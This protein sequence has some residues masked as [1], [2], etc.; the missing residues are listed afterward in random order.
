[1]N[2]GNPNW[3]NLIGDARY[4]IPAGSGVN[5][6]YA[7]S[8]W[9]AGLDQYGT[10][11]G[12]M[13]RF[14]QDGYDFWPG[15]IDENGSITPNECVDNDRIYKLNRWEVA[16]FRQRLGTVGYVIPT[17][18]LEWPAAGNPNSMAHADA[19]FKDVNN[20]G[21]YNAFDGDYP[22]FAFD[23][24][25]NRNYHLLGDQCLW[26]VENDLGN[27]HTETNCSP[28]HMEMQYMAYAFSTCDELNNQTFYRC[29]VMNK[30]EFDF[31]SMYI[32]LWADPDIGFAQDD[33]VQC[34]VMRHLGFAYN[35]YAIDGTGG[36]GQYGTHPPAAGIGILEGPLADAN[37]GV[38]NDRDGQV[39]EP[40]EHLMMSHFMYHNNSGQGDPVTQD[41]R[42]CPDHYWFLRGIWKDGTPM[43]YGGTGNPAGGCD[44]SVL[45]DFMFPG[46]SDPMGYGTG[47]VPQPAWTEQTSGNVPYDRRFLMSSGPFSFNAGETEYIHYGALWARDTV[48][49]DPYSSAEK[50]Y[51]VKDLCQ[52]KFD[53]NFEQQGCCPPQAQIEYQS[54]STFKFFFASVHEGTSYHWDFGDG[55]TWSGRFPLQH[56]YQDFGTYEVCLTV[57]NDCGS[58]TACET[59][60]ISEPPVGVRLK[61]IEGFGN[62]G[63]KLEFRD[64]VHD[65]LFVGTQ[66][67]IF[68]PE[69]EFNQGPV[70]IEIL[71]STLLPSLQMAL[72]LDG[73]GDSSGWKIYPLGGSDTVYSSST[74]GVGYQQLIP[75][76]GLLVQVKQANGW[77]GNCNYV[78][79]CSIEQSSNPWLK[80][81]EDT[82][83]PD[84]SNWIRSGT[85]SGVDYD[86][87][88][89][90]DQQEC[91][92]HI[93]EGT[94]APYKMAN[95][96][97]SIASPTWS[98]FKSLSNLN[99]LHS[100]DIVIT[101]DQ[102]KWTRCGVVEICDYYLPSVGGARRFD[103]RHS[104]S[105]DKN[106]T[107]DGS[108]TMGLSWFPGY[109]VDLET[110]ERL[111][112]AFGENSW[113]QSEHGADMIWNPTS[114]E[115]AS[116]IP[117]LGG[118]HYIYVFGHSS[119]DPE[120]MPMYDEAEFISQMLSENDYAPGDPNKRRVF[121]D[122]MWVGIPMLE[123]G[124]Q[125][126]ESEVE[127]KLRVAKPFSDYR[128]LDEEVN[129]THP[130]Y[131]FNT[132]ALGTSI[133]EVVGVVSRISVYP[134]PTS[135]VVSIVNEGMESINLMQLYNTSGQEVLS[136]KSF[137]SKGM[138]TQLNLD[139][140]ERGV[141]FLVLRGEQS[142]DVKK[143]ILQ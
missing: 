11:R 90:S 29:K 125:L 22:A 53:Q 128:C 105:V 15:P 91:L 69:Y 50:L 85:V 141:Y 114:S 108:G 46:D 130:L 78:L 82:D 110:G 140:L 66:N 55:T 12:S 48:Q 61:R 99:D 136:K 137:L 97:D 95:H 96:A 21:I 17:D 75:Q 72:A 103:L 16:E 100:V 57:E 62:M 18:I 23:E 9:F 111:N 119:D 71:D 47:G 74:I 24:P 8:M 32:G 58:S 124:H 142:A 138:K 73:A 7:G 112:M 44:Q 80:W 94:W 65:S 101:S 129:G 132:I 25:V 39:D 41:P 131:W 70:R 98:K 81:L 118:G 116:G 35:G 3:W 64:G 76:W 10:L 56:T 28:M 33:Y 107:P 127:I 49:V 113:L 120:R 43:C 54:H 67:R 30:G 13:V 6:F 83:Y 92:E 135:D 36:P 88:S 27:T 63:R 2:L 37:D 59:V 14:G 126:L 122:A 19:P 42:T 143:L 87:N 1:M 89:Q 45:A 106:G 121:S 38:D 40:G 123:Q 20:D 5:C 60:I 102:S 139:G 117:L 31:H 77:E 51:L 52:E 4:E 79:D 26:W 109:A 104:P 84:Y 134:N 93:L 34:E 115:S 133:Q 68:H 86:F